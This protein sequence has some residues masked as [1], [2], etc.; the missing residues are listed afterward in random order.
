D[1]DLQLLSGISCCNRARF[2]VEESSWSRAYFDS[3]EGIQTRDDLSTRRP[4]YVDALFP[5]GAVEAYLADAPVWLKPLARLLGFRGNAEDGLAN[6]R[7]AADS[8]V[9]TRVEAGFYLGYYYYSV[10]KDI[11]QADVH[12]AELYAQY[13]QNPVF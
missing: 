6:L 1:V 11:D 3:R 8:G 12:F 10:R 4:D 5:P 7:K 9:W 2:H 13:P